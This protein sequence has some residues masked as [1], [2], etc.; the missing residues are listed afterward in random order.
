[1]KK[2]DLEKAVIA[3]GAKPL[4]GTKHDKWIS[5]NGYV[6]TIPRHKEIGEALA[7]R[8]IKQSHM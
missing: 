2:R 3:N 7:K 6:F 5:K 8:I 1:M 4:N